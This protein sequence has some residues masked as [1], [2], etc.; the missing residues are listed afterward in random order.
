MMDA[1]DMIRRLSGPVSLR[2]RMAYVVAL[3][4]GLGG[5]L[6]IGLLWATEERP[7]PVFGGFAVLCLAWACYGGWALTRRTPLFALDRVIGGWIAVAAT[8]PLTLLTV[9]LAV[10]RPG[11]AGW[12]GAAVNVVLALVAAFVLVRA[13]SARAALLRRKR[14]LGG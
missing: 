13:R 11:W 6:A 5:A 4:M 12:A 14:E 10:D 8:W 9:A 7:P 1:D 3:V 2:R